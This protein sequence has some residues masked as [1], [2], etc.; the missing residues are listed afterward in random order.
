MDYFGIVKKAYEITIKHKFLWIFGIL[1]GGYGGIRSVSNMGNYSGTGTEWQ[2][3]I[4]NLNSLTFESFWSQYGGLIISLGI[5]VFIFCIIMFIL[6]IVSQGG[7]VSSVAKLSKGEKSDFHDGFQVGFRN[8]WRVWA[9]NLIYFSMILI[10]L[11]I[12]LAPAA[13]LAMTGGFI[14]ALIWGILFFFVSL[15]FWILIAL[16][17]PYSIRVVILEKLGIVASVRESLH[18]FRDHWG[19]VLLMYLIVIGF[20]MAFGLAMTLIILILGAI[21][22][23]IGYA[24]WL[25]SFAAALVYGIVLGLAFLGVIL[26]VSGAFGAFTSAILTLTYQELTKKS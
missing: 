17:S 3:S 9:V 13:V 21:L 25:A 20:G 19:K 22:L 24:I 7:L 8:F 4:N 1:A 5:L 15:A 23:A 16:I 18:F 11:L 10:S 6:N 14:F 26:T 12:W 2:N